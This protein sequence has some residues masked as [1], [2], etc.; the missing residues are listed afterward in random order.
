M[1]AKSTLPF[2]LLVCIGCLGCRSSSTD[3]VALSEHYG[4]G[5]VLRVVILEQ[6]AGR[7]ELGTGW[8]DG[9]TGTSRVLLLPVSAKEA[10]RLIASVG[11]LAGTSSICDPANEFEAEFAMQSNLVLQCRQRGRERR[12]VTGSHKISSFRVVGGL[13]EEV[14]AVGNVGLARA[15]DAFQRAGDLATQGDEDAA[16]RVYGHAVQWFITW[17][18]A[19]IDRYGLGEYEPF[20]VEVPIPNRAIEITGDAFDLTRPMLSGL[21]PKYNQ[22]AIAALRST[23]EELTRDYVSFSVSGE[24]TT[25]SIR[26]DFITGGRSRAPTTIPSCLL[27]HLRGEFGG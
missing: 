20:L 12:I 16:I 6:G 3:V 15:I 9:A 22:F 11:A 18:H 23:W 7:V 10:G 24:T 8:S 27:A 4:R 5:D 17:C 25:V 14:E 2:L 1:Y 26:T 19:R 21:E 13:V